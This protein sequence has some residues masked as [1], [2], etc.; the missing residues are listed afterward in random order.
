MD[1]DNQGLTTDFSPVAGDTLQAIYGTG[2][3]AL[4]TDLHAFH[5]DQSGE[6]SGLTEKAVPHQ[7][8]P[9]LA[10]NSQASD[11]KVY[12]KVSSILNKEWQLVIDEPGTSIANWTSGGGTWSTD[13]TFLKQTDTT[14]VWRTLKCNTVV[15]LG[16]GAILEFDMKIPTLSSLRAAGVVLGYSGTNTSPGACFN[17]RI[18]GAGTKEAYFERAFSTTLLTLSPASAFSGWN[19]TLQTTFRIHCTGGFLSAYI[20]GTTLIGSAGS[21]PANAGDARFIGLVTFGTE[22]HF[23]NIK[24]WVPKVYF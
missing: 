6:I 11:S 24:L 4:P 12:I 1:G 15:D 17:A 22:A 3:L 13:G 9:L 18:T 20:G 16:L 21:T 5:D 8:D 2:S 14:A 7:D 23:A 19:P 10:E